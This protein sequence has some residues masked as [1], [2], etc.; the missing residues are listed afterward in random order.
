MENAYTRRHNT[1]LFSILYIHAATRHGSPALS[2]WGN[3][4]FA[5]IPICYPKEIA[6]PG[7][8]WGIP[9]TFFRYDN[10]TYIQWDHP[11]YCIDRYRVV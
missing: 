3:T 11:W 4:I 7:H 6:A 1:Q 8:A 9:D 5:H 2:T 10:G